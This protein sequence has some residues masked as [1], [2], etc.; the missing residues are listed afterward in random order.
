[1]CQIISNDNQCFPFPPQGSPSYD[2]YNLI[3]GEAVSNCQKENNQSIT[4]TFS[5]EIQISESWSVDTTIGSSFSALNVHS[6]G[7]WSSS[8]SLR[9]SQ[10]L[11]L[12]IPPGNVVCTPT[13]LNEDTHIYLL[14]LFS[15]RINNRSR[16]PEH[17]RDNAYWLRV[18]LHSQLESNENDEIFD[19]SF[20]FS[21][22][23]PVNVMNFVISYIDCGSQFNVS[24]LST[25][26]CTKSTS[27]AK[28]ISCPLMLMG[29]VVG[30]VIFWKMI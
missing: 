23:Q 9:A 25:I 27:V 19:S 15:G 30:I 14:F 29:S 16:L 22:L 4:V 13:F 3:V 12:T 10:A 5:R 17:K 18:R 6:S 11:I 21:S 7:N 20:N 2:T 1:M 26:E 8:P 28:K 24:T